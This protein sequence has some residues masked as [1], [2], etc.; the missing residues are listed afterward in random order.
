MRIQTL[1]TSPKGSFTLAPYHIFGVNTATRNEIQAMSSFCKNVTGIFPNDV[2]VAILTAT[3][4][5][6]EEIKK[7]VKDRIKVSIIESSQGIERD[8]ILVVITHND[9]KH[10]GKYNRLKVALTRARKALYICA[11]LNVCCHPVSFFKTLK[12]CFSKYASSI[13]SW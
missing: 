2:G 5:L 8:I 6:K 13:G 9:I 7:K 3:L 10:F 12:I 1:S 11:G 4:Q